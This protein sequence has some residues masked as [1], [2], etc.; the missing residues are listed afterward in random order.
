MRPSPN[1]NL[2]ASCSNDHTVRIWSVESRDCQAVLRG[3]EHVVECITWASH[4]QSLVAI[5]T[6]QNYSNEPLLSHPNTPNG[7]VGVDNPE[8]SS[9]NIV[10]SSTLILV[11]G[12][13][14]RTIRFW[15]GNNGVCL[16][17]LVSL[18]FILIWFTFLYYTLPYK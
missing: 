16:F 18:L 2:L 10:V 12:S 8:P 7:V 6:G 5:T 14:D 4:P 17:V 13:R 3:H 9:N 15:D 11:S 1:G